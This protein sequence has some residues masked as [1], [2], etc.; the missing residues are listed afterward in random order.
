MASEFAAPV[1]S[2]EQ[3]NNHAI[4][5][6]EQ[7]KRYN[8]IPVN[9]EE[10]VEFDLGIDIFPLPNLQKTYDIEGFISG[11]LTTIY[12]DEFIYNYRPTR[13]R[14][15]LAHEVGHFLFHKELMSAVHPQSTSGWKEFVL[16]IDDDTYSWLEYQAY[17]FASAVLM[18]R[19]F[20]KNLY[21]KEIKLLIPKVNKARNAGFSEEMLKDYIIDAVAPKLAVSFDVSLGVARRRIA[22]EIE[23]LHLSLQGAP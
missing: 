3:I 1:L 9:I 2:Y 23:M 20:L 16:G 15:S 18:P 12:V 5:F 10:T 19:S 11:D 13:Y 7:N 22:K 14:Y 8:T 21:S 17:T 6:L 4:E